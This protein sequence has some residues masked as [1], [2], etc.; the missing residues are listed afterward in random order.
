[1]TTTGKPHEF[2]DRTT[3]RAYTGH[4]QH[5]PEQRAELLH[6]SGGRYGFGSGLKQA[7]TL[8]NFLE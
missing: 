7:R 8:M 2:F 5:E 3:I 1:M 6:K 4:T